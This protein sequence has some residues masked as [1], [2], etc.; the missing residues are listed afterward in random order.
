VVAAPDDLDLLATPDLVATVVES[1][2]QAFAAVEAAQPAIIKAVDLLVTA[3][4]AGGRW[5]LLGAGTSGRLAV[6]EASEVPGTYGVPSSRIQARVAGGGADALVGIDAAEDDEALGV[7]DLDDLAASDADVVIAVTA[8]GTTPYT[9]RA[10]GEA[11]SRGCRLV[12]VTTVAGSPL[13]SFADVAIE[14][15]VGAEVVIGST[16]MAAGTAQK[17]VLNTLT[18][19]A[20]VR[21]GRV[22]GNHMID[23]E[24]ANEKLRQRVATA[25]SKVTGSGF[26]QAWQALVACDWHARAAIVHLETGL[27]PAE[28]KARADRHRT[29]RDAINDTSNGIAGGAA[30]DG[31][32]ATS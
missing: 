3:Y 15:E 32:N 25:I 6:M 2:R 26:E 20:M 22:H 9:L 19:A 21:L 12:S 10:A 5:L 13:A 8:S 28:A 4:D 18:T 11:K 27:D 29:V 31:I 24:P 1:Q 30:N 16:R 17:L 23:V 14:P 7:R